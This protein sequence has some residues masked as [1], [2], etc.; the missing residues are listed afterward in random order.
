M[1]VRA[2][3]WV[4][5]VCRVAPV[6]AVL[7]VRVRREG[8]LRRRRVE[9]VGGVLQVGRRVV[10][11]MV[12]VRRGVL[13]HVAE[14]SVVWVHGARRVRLHSGRVVQVGRVRGV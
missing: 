13:G 14:L 6:G 5:G 3:R 2:M 9:L 4:G 10:V 1:V 11:V 8:R 12:V 7:R